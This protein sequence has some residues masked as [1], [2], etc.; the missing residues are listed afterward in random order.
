MRRSD[1]LNELTEDRLRQM[2]EDA[3][4]LPE[5]QQEAAIERIHHLAKLWKFGAPWLEEVTPDWTWD[6]PHLKLIYEALHRVTT[7]Q[8]RRLAIFLPPRHGK[9]ESVTVRYAAWRLERDPSTRIILGAYNESQALL[10]SRKIKRIVS[11]RVPLAPGT[12]RIDDWETT[13]AGGL[14]SVGVGGGVTGRGANCLPAGTLVRT[15]RGDVDISHLVRLH[16]QY[17]VLVFDH[18]A[19]RYGWRKIIATRESLADELTELETSGGRKVRATSE[20]RFYV[21]GKGY[22]PAK[23]LHPGDRLISAGVPIEQDVLAVRGSDQKSRHF[24][25]GLLLQSA[26]GRHRSEVRVLRPGVREAALRVRKGSSARTQRL[27]LREGVLPGAPCSE[28]REP[29]RSLRQAESRQAEHQ[30]L[31]GGVREGWEGNP[32]ASPGSTVRPLRG[33]LSPALPPDQILRERVCNEGA[34][35]TDAGAWKFALQGRHQLRALVR[36]NDAVDPCTGRSGLRD[37]RG[38]AGAEA[39]AVAR[40][41]DLEVEPSDPSSRRGPGE[42]PGREPDDALSG[43]PYDASQVCYDTVAVVRRVRAPRERVY[44]IQVDGTSNFFAG[45]ILVHNCIIID[46]PVKSREEAESEAYRDRCWGWYRDDLWTRQEPGASIVLIQTRWHEDDLAGRVLKDMKSGGEQWEIVNLPA[47]AETQEERDRWAAQIGLPVGLPDPLGREP[48]RALCPDRYNE[49][50]LEAAKIV[51]GRSFYA[52]YQ[53]RPTAAEGGLFKKEWFRSFKIEGDVYVL[54]V[55]NAADRRI[56]AASCWIFQTADLAGTEKKQGDWTVICTWAVTPRN[57]LLLLDVHRFQKEGP[58]VEIEIEN[59][60]SA[61]RPRFVVVEKNGLAL[62]TVQNLTRKGYPIRGVVT[63]KSKV[64]RVGAAQGPAARYMAGT[65]Y[66]LAGATWLPDWENEHLNFPG[67]HDDQ[68]DNSSL[69]S[70]TIVPGAAVFT[71]FSHVLHIAPEILPFDPERPL[72]CAWAFKPAVVWVAT[73]LMADGRWA[74]LA[75]LEAEPS[76]GLLDFS[77]RVSDHMTREFGRP[78]TLDVRN[79]A[80]PEYCGFDSHR[81]AEFHDAWLLLAEGMRVAVGVDDDGI[82][83]EETREKRAWALEPSLESQTG[84]LE[85]I[86]ARLNHLIHGEPALQIDP[87]AH[88]VIQAF[89]GGYRNKELPLGGYSSIP[90]ENKYKAVVEALGCAAGMLFANTTGRER[91]DVELLLPY[92]EPTGGTARRRRAA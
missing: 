54:T 6:W 74:I 44:D 51:L 57:E 47:L 89:Q 72:I 59:R 52:L 19:G 26:E 3:L 53:Q 15:D 4:A 36:S 75:A 1:P 65:M 30:V 5:H 61:F 67:A 86:R 45:E 9:S 48:G 50:D 21:A 41:D 17:R 37:L 23:D 13:E 68:V 2:V 32:S 73:Q 85:L 83:L 24:V 70:E 71:E 49:Q 62:P 92:G 84:R 22:V 66:H 10:Y 25:L 43:V 39:G 46:D 80:L 81:S 76:E 20:H 14:R 40:E 63:R 64:D 60:F 31:L 87:E 11:G 35:P 79:G 27:L 90:E 88:L 34:L 91:D 16:S 8:I 28:A 38:A 82:V 18:S 56:P 12:R 29:V 69:A 77:R 55:P 78:D 42:Q 33:H 7:G 58:E